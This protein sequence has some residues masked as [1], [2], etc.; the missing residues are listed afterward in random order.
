MAIAD[1][2][3]VLVVDDM[4]DFAQML[5]LALEMKGYA[6][7]TALNAMAA[8]GLIEDQQ[9]DCVI[10]DIGM[11]GV[12]GLDFARV[13]REKF[14]DDIVLIAASGYSEDYRAVV[15]AFKKI[16][17]RL[18]YPTF[19]VSVRLCFPTKFVVRFRL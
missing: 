9:P 17:T 15:D 18:R 14:G 10:L 3:R 16:K 5:A 4:V 11:P 7:R 8:L 13:L 6:V 2:V 19:Q 12:S 1:P